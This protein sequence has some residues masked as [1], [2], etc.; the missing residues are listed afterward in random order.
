[1]GVNDVMLTGSDRLPAPSTPKTVNVYS[2]FRFA[3]WISARCCEIVKKILRRC[4]RVPA[5]EVQTRPRAVKAGIRL[6][7]VPKR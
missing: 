2:P 5:S 6:Q 7:S 4:D 1:M 3:S